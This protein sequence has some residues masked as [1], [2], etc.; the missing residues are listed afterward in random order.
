MQRQRQRGSSSWERSLRFLVGLS[1]SGWVRLVAKVTIA[2]LVAV[3]VVLITLL[4]SVRHIGLQVREGNLYL[5]AFEI[6]QFTAA[7]EVQSLVVQKSRERLV[8]GE[9]QCETGVTE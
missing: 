4:V 5:G 1:H 8:Y 7:S 9:S 6:G 2:L 3:T